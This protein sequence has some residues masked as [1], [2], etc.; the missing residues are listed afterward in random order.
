MEGFSILLYALQALGILIWIQR[1]L[2]ALLVLG[3]VLYFMKRA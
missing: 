1:F 2:V 3:A